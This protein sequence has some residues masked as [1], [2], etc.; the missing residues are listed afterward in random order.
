MNGQIHRPAGLVI[1]TLATLFVG[2]AIMVYLLMIPGEIRDTSPLLILLIVGLAAISLLWM[3]LTYGLWTFQ[4]WAINLGKFVYSL[5]IIA[6]VASFFVLSSESSFFTTL[7]A[8]A[9]NASMLQYISRP[10]IVRLFEPS[11]RQGMSSV[12]GKRNLAPKAPPPF[13]S[14]GSRPPL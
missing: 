11:S 2:L 10:H 3:T 5:G 1:T 9:I 14:R 12:G 7:L 13:P 4:H 6:N 8:I